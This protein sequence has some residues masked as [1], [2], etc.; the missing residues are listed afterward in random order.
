MLEQFDHIETKNLGWLLLRSFVASPHLANSARCLGLKGIHFDRV[1]FDWWVDDLLKGLFVEGRRRIVRLRQELPDLFDVLDRGG[2]V[3]TSDHTVRALVKWFINEGH[4][5]DDARN[6]GLS[7]RIDIADR[8]RRR[9]VEACLRYDLENFAKFLL[10]NGKRRGGLSYSRSATYRDWD[11][12]HETLGRVSVRVAGGKHK[13]WSISAGGKYVFGWSKALLVQIVLKRDLPQALDW[14]EAYIDR[15]DEQPIKSLP[16]VF[17]RLLSRA[18]DQPPHTVT[19]SKPAG[20]VDVIERPAERPALAAPPPPDAQDED[21]SLLQPARNVEELPPEA[22]ATAAAPPAVIVEEEAPPPTPAAPKSIEEQQPLP[23][24]RAAPA[25]IEARNLAAALDLVKADFPIFAAR[26]DFK[27]G[28]WKK[29]PI[30]KG[31]QVVRADQGR[32]RASW[33]QYPKAVPGIALGRA[34]LVVVDVDRHGGPD[35]VATFDKLVA[36]HGGLPP[37]PVVRTASGGFHYYFRQP[38]G[39]PLGNHEGALTGCG[40]NVRGHT[41]WVVGPGAVCPDGSEWRT[42]DGAASLVEAYRNGTIPVIPRW[43]VDMIHGPKPKKA[44]KEKPEKSE[45]ET[46]PGAAPSSGK[47]SRSNMDRRGKAWAE[48]VLKN[49]VAELAAKP[50]HS[51][52][53]ELANSTAFQLGTMVARGW[54][55]RG[56]VVDALMFASEANGKVQDDGG[57]DRIRDT[58]ERAI[59]AGMLEPHPDLADGRSQAGRQRSGEHDGN[60]RNMLRSEVMWLQRIRPGGEYATLKSADD[61]LAKIGSTDG[62]EIGRILDFKFSDYLEIGRRRGRCPSVLRPVDKTDDEIRAH[63]AGIRNSPEKKAAK[64]EAERARR[65]RIKQE[66]PVAPTN[67]LEAR[68]CAAL[69]AYLKQHPGPQSIG[70]LVGALKRSRAFGGLSAKGLRTALLRLLNGASEKSSPLHG[71]VLLTTST[72]KNRKVTFVVELVK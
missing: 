64:A 51:G 45:A 19:A 43:I 55:D 29:Q 32:V 36:E 23:L 35:G 11:A 63:R 68:R 15:P 34:G 25:D 60:W 52:R 65:L 20:A 56:T 7:D 48:T 67:E 31:W 47:P 66:A 39:K 9:D 42:A 28:R 27:E 37:G 30:T 22:P 38:T 49:G 5:L 26:V 13:D 61:V 41:G 59:A 44:P 12:Q 53:N 4:Y 57:S 17:T 24:D 69:V 33:R 50:P 6:L 58:I 21:E 72:A 16:E 18:S 14:I 46:T 70:K 8:N 54:V 10:P 62:R 2:P 1:G 3:V 71:R 40:I